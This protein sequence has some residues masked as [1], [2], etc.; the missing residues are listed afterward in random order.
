MKAIQVEEFEKEL[1]ILSNASSERNSINQ[2]SPLAT[3]DAVL[4]DNDILR[5]GGRIE[6]ATASLA[7]RHPIILPRQNH[8]SNLVIDHYHKE[9]GHSGR[10]MTMNAVQQAEYW[11]VG[12]RTA[13]TRHIWNC[14]DCRKLRGPAGSQKMANLPKDRLEPA[15]PFTYSA[16]NCFGPFTIK[17]GRKELKRWGVLFTCMSSRAIHIETANSMDTSSFLNAYRRFVCRRGPIRQLRSDRGT[18]FIGGKNELSAAMT[19]MDDSRI[20]QELLK[21]NCDWFITNFNVPHASHMGGTWERMIRCAR[22]ALASLLLKNGQQLDDELL[23]TLMTEAES[24]V[25]SRP[26]TFIETSSPDML[27]PICPSHLLTL[28]TKVVQPLPGVFVREDLY[29]RQRWRRVQYLANQF[30]TQWRNQFL[31]TLQQRQKW[32]KTKTNMAVSD[33][34]LL[35]D[36]SLPCCQWPLGRVVTVHPSSDGLV[37]KVTVKTASSEYD[38]PVHKVI[39]LLPNSQEG[40]QEAEASPS[41]SQ[42]VN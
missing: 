11:I 34:V 17:E 40:L 35:V 19:E 3:L 31:P 41:K 39:P 21:T 10:R 32:I 27:T 36:E 14:V 12:L 18:N 24:I 13:V 28:K 38:R 9:T 5:V 42:Q 4:G 33:V 22:N 15:A 1:K 25:N 16:V 20:A 23:R 29:C 26:L 2:Q 30:W 6:E 8:I 7:V 37:R